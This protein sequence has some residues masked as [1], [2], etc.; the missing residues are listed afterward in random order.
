MDKLTGDAVALD[1]ALTKLRAAAADPRPERLAEL[2][3]DEAAALLGLLDTAGRDVRALARILAALEDAEDAARAEFRAH[4][5]RLHVPPG[6]TRPSIEWRRGRL[7]M[8]RELHAAA[9]RLAREAQ[10]EEVTPTR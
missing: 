2:L 1:A 4:R 5:D 3:R 10:R 6:E 8:A 7:S 9:G